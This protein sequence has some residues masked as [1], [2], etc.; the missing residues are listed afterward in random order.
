[1][2]NRPN[3]ALRPGGATGVTRRAG[4]PTLPILLAL[5]AWILVAPAWA[6]PQVDSE[7]PIDIDLVAADLHQVLQ[8]FAAIG[9]AELDATSDIT[10]EVTVHLEGVP[11]A[12]AL[13][14]VCAEHRLACRWRGGEPPTLEVRQAAGDYAGFPE[15]ISLELAGAERS[16]VLASFPVITDEGVVL[17]GT[18]LGKVTLELK[19]VPWTEGLLEVCAGGGCDVDFSARPVVVS[20]P[21]PPAAPSA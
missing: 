9:A 19:D 10:G 8:S 7:E 15:N 4:L 16:Q 20:A 5:V 17:E 12:R 1:M 14:E 18:F 21:E 6:A 2:R 13:D 3:R 11:W